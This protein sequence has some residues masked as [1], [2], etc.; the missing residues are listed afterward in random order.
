MLKLV[1]LKFLKLLTLKVL[2]LKVLKDPTVLAVLKHKVF[3]L[4]E[5][6]FFKVLSFIR[7]LSFSAFP[8]PYGF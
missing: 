8:R 1:K 6:N 5:L 2:K 4:L 7:F 3:R